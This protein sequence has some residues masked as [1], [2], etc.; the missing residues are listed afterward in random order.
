MKIEDVEDAAL[1]CA[2][3]EDYY[4]N[5]SMKECLIKFQ[6]SH[7]WIILHTTRYPNCDVI[8]LTCKKCRKLKSKIV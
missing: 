8:L 5:V 3:F 6:C 1:D 4:Y 7:E 2:L